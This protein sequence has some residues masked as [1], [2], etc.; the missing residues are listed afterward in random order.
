MAAIET[1]G[2]TLSEREYYSKRSEGF[3]Y[4]SKAFN[5]LVHV[6]NKQ[7]FVLFK[8]N[9]ENDIKFER[10][11]RGQMVVRSSDQGYVQLK[12]LVIQD[13]H[14]IDNIV[15]QNFK[16][17]NPTPDSVSFKNGE[18]LKLLK[19]LESI[20]FIDPGADEKIRIRIDEIDTSKALVDASDL[21]IL[22]KFKNIDL[23]KRSELLSNL[24]GEV[25]PED[26]NILSGRRQGLE[27][28]R[29]KL[30]QEKDWDEPKWQGF[31]E[32]NTWIFGYGLDYR[33]LNILQR[34][35]KLSNIDL[36]GTDTVSGDFLLGSNEF[37]VLVEIKKPDTNL[38]TERRNRARTWELSHD[39]TNA[40]SQIL[41][42]KAEWELKAAMSPDLYVSGKRMSQRTYDP[43][44]ILIIGD[45]DQYAG[46]DESE[47]LKA[48]TFELYRRNSRNVEI[49]TY[50]ELFER[51]YYIV[52]QKKFER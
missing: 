47:V 1:D 23:D 52:N 50:T 13:S 38:F 28:F 26:L 46:T 36:D 25:T 20:Q 48:K 29:L 6:S 35:A 34:E 22:E 49:L 45:T 8:I 31:F 14:Q 41:A 16:R 21:D 43:K 37:T 19:F 33:F 9:T 42:Q 12:A 30:F 17:G 4:V 51:A 18:F 5:G 27:Q 39:I 3:A 10:P 44:V 40:M 15:I 11:I 7:R 2:T 24:A 32:Q